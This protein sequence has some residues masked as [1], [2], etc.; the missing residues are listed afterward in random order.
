MELAQKF[1]AACSSDVLS[2]SSLDM[3][4]MY[5]ILLATR[6]TTRFGSCIV[7][8]PQESAERIGKIFLPS[9]YHSVFSD[10]DIEDINSQRVSGASCLGEGM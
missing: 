6:V 7:L 8:S 10:M 9:R 2:I 3:G 5:P 4:K 1:E